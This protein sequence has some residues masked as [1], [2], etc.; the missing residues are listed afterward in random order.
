MLVTRR[1]FMT[2]RQWRRVFFLLCLFMIFSL[3]SVSAKGG[4]EGGYALFG[5]KSS[6]KRA[7]IK[8]TALIIQ[9]FN[10]LTG[11]AM[12]DAVALSEHYLDQW[13]AGKERILAQ[14]PMI[15]E[16]DTLF[17][18]RL[19][20]ELE[21][22]DSRLDEEFDAAIDAV[23]D[24]IEEKTLELDQLF[25]ESVERLKTRAH[26]RLPANTGAVYAPY[27]RNERLWPLRLTFF[28]HLVENTT[29]DLVID[30]AGEGRSEEAIRSSIVA[31]DA[32]MREGRLQ[33]DMT[34]HIIPDIRLDYDFDGEE[35][36]GSNY[37]D[38]V[39]FLFVLDEVAVTDDQGTVLFSRSLEEPVLFQTI[40]VDDELQ[41]TI[42]NDDP[43]FGV[44]SL[45]YED[46][47]ERE[48]TLRSPEESI[49]L[50]DPSVSID[51]S[52]E[53]ERLAELSPPVYTSAVVEGQGVV[54]DAHAV[55]DD[56][57]GPVMPDIPLFFLDDTETSFD[58]VRAGRPAIVNYFASW[59]PTC[60]AELP[61]FEEA[62]RQ[63]GDEVAFIFLDA[64]DGQRETKATI[65]KFIKEFPFEAP[66]YRDEGIFAYIFQTNSLPTTVFFDSDGHIV[67]GFMGMVSEQTLED[68]IALL[69][70]EG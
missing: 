35:D 33:W 25:E 17:A 12:E 49:L 63:Y 10:G 22:L 67:T 45:Y 8:A 16:T 4:S 57:L 41:F 51:A 23:Y 19:A 15:W 14:E 50:A 13:N 20:H 7:N 18:E 26:I 39:R 59:V 58:E 40:T 29:L 61:Y 31:F 30:F 21:A 5:A 60:R 28:D 1:R 69:L 62:W 3:L 55:E 2:K 24:C 44:A 43:D 66:V 68:A 38:L 52:Y 37:F 47:I 48:Q 46:L 64:L 53:E 6:D 56:E 36:D 65:G 9:D 34:Y 11:A 42:R 54:G 32:M 70:N 27:L